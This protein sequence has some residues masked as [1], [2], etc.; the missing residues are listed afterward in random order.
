MELSLKKSCKGL[1]SIERTN[2]LHSRGK[3][4]FV[5]DKTHADK[6]RHYILHT[7][8][9]DLE[10]NGLPVINGIVAG[11]AG[12]LMGTTTVGNYAEVLKKT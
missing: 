3:W 6:I 10:E 4:H 11:V 1:H 12:S 7:V 8:I 5:V 2:Q 9:P